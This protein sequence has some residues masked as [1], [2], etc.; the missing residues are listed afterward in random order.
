MGCVLRVFGDHLDVH[1]AVR[2]IGLA[3]YRVDEK[4]KDGRRLNCLHFEVIKDDSQTFD[5]NI[6]EIKK[7]IS[8]NE[9]F[10]RSVSERKDVGGV[11]LDLAV[12]FLDT[13]HSKNLTIDPMFIK[14]LAKFDLYL[15]LTIYKVSDENNDLDDDIIMNNS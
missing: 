9:S 8:N 5:E 1:D 11:T 14:N 15:E 13:S 2:A 10:L 12:Y 6:S 7:Y 3:P 4:G